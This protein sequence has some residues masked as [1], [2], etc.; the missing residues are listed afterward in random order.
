MPSCY[1]PLY[2]YVE[3]MECM[4]A[5]CEAANYALGRESRFN[6]KILA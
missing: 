3:C 6:R 4:T 5:L 2:V 1:D